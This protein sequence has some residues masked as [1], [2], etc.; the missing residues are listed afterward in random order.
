MKKLLVI[1]LVA[2]LA[3]GLVGCKSIEEKI[4][5]EIGEEIAGGVLGGDVE[6][7]GDAVTIE[8][9]EGEVTIDSTEGELPDDFPNDF[10]I[11]DDAEV[12]STSSWAGE[13]DITFY[14]NLFSD[15]E[16]KEV[17]DWYKDELSGEGWTIDSDTFIT[18]DSDGGL[19][20]AT[21]DTS[22]LTLSVSEDTDNTAIGIILVINGD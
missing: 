4:G 20:G 3:L 13:G 6:V 7:D 11:Y 1:A 12:E 21:K 17:Y 14:V 15:D 16:A 10:P 22:Q 19:M 9:D 8:T 5:E 18:G 2:A